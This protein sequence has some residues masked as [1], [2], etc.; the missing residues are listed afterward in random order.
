VWQALVCGFLGVRVERGVLHVDPCL[1]TA[2]PW[3]RV[4]LHALGA[5]VAITAD[6][7][8]IRVRTDRPLRVAAPGHRAVEVTGEVAFDRD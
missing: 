7:A 2:W 3:L 4:R 1:P 6:A 5:R 8:T